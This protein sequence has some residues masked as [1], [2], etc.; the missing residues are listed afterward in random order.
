MSE[1]EYEL[2]GIIVHIG[3]AESGHYIS[4]IK[5]EENRWLQFNDSLIS[6]FS[7]M[8]IEAECFGGA[9]SAFEDDFEW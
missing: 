7:A 6:L 2:T 1:Y 3:N 4:F 5:T 8:S 9:I